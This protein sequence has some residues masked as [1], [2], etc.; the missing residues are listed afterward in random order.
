MVDLINFFSN[1][2]N[3]SNK[4]INFFKGGRCVDQI[5]GYYCMWGDKIGLM[6]ER[7]MENPCTIESLI[8]GD[9][10]FEVIG[11][12]GNTYLECTGLETFALRKCQGKLYW[13]QVE[14]IC[15]IEYAPPKTDVC[16]SYPC[17]NHGVCHDLGGYNFKCKCKSGYTGSL[18]ETMIDF[19]L[20]NPCMNG[21]RCVP[22]I[23]GY[24]CLCQNNVIDKSC[25]SG[26]LN[27]NHYLINI[28]LL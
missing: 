21:G 17:Q 25:S 9:Q 3:I 18:C 2:L 16:K 5:N 24:N 13:H 10:F 15:S 28:Q 26:S 1:C 8:E 6:Y 27:L 11:P 12:H 7:R 19:C 20:S 22:H 4:L 14:K 23:N